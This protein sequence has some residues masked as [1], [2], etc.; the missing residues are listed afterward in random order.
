MAA[1][2]MDSNNGL[3]RNRW[4]TIIWSQ[5]WGMYWSF[6]YEYR[7]MGTQEVFSIFIYIILGRT[8]T[9]VLLTQPCLKQWCCV[10]LMYIIVTRPQWVIGFNTSLI[11][12]TLLSKLM[13]T[14]FTDTYYIT[15][16][17]NQSSQ[18]CFLHKVNIMAIER[19]GTISGHAPC[20]REGL[21]VIME[22]HNPSVN[23]M[24]RGI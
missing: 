5:G 22:I 13:L 8:S 19:H 16:V 7:K 15:I 1:L 11:G 14:Q 20:I 10:L 12:D 24:H 6:K 3:V 4:H 17:V 23:H 18:H 2:S 9:R 21:W